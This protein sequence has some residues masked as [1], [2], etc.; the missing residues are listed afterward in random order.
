MYQA[1]LRW[2]GS[3][4]LGWGRYERAHEAVAPPA[5]QALTLTTG[6]NRGDPRLL[7]PEQLVVMAVSSCQL[8]WFLHLAAKARV[9][10][11]EYADSADAQMPGDRITAITLRPRIVVASETSEQRVRRLVEL[12]HER[13][14]VA[15]SL[16]SDV[17]IEPTIELH[18]AA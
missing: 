4:G 7:N 18:A 16:R 5:R 9:D 13:C 17:A 8:L 14:N 11:V 15:N 3:T 10:I 2:E 12:A 6:E 1:K